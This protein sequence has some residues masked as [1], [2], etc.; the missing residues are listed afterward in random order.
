MKKVSIVGSG[1]VGVN[2]AFFIAEMGAGH[3]TLV[4]VKEGIAPGKALDLMEAA[5]I[6][7]YRTRIEGSDEIAAIE[8]S[9]VVVLAAGRIREPGQDR[10]EHFED[11]ASTV[12]EICRKVVKYARDAC[13]IVA[14][15]PVDAMV[16]V[17]AEATGFDRHKVMGIGGI[18]DST[19][20]AHFIAARLG[21]SPRDVT[22]LVVGSHTNQ[23]VPLPY[24]SRVNGIQIDQLL[25]PE[26]VQVIVNE[27][28]EAGTVIV[29]LS[30]Q[31]NAYY[32]PS[33]AIAQVA[34]AICIDTKKVMPLSVVLDGEYG[35]SD[36]ALSVPCKVGAGGIEDIISITLRGEDLQDFEASAEP[37]RQLF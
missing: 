36:V 18:L 35:M 10:L 16:M 30:K 3:V 24:Y 2:S 34:E 19:R 15:E 13:V 12:R 29:E 4:D 32:A 28:R 26:A 17:T 25:S 20:M 22:A 8:G 9:D 37:I 21:V 27:T 14:T 31:A 23:M 6:R 7:S 1:N 33:S 5:P 11:N